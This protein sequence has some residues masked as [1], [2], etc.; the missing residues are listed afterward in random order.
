M[1]SWVLF[2]VNSL[3]LVLF[4]VN[5]LFWVLFLSIFLSQNHIV[6]YFFEYFFEWLQFFLVLFW[7]NLLFEFFLSDFSFLSTFL[8]LIWDFWSLRTYMLS[9]LSGNTLFTFCSLLYT[10]QRNWISRPRRYLMVYT[11]EVR[12]ICI[13]N[14]S[15]N[16]TNINASRAEATIA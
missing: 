9:L 14:D 7:V 6:F 16:N 4:W 13:C 11:R 1:L 3:F 8:V 12:C 2:W 5:F 10:V 15:F